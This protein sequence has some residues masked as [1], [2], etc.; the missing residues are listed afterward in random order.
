MTRSVAI[1][2]TIS[3]ACYCVGGYLSKLYANSPSVSLFLMA[4]VAFSACS[5]AWLPAMK[6]VNLLAVLGLIWSV[7]YVVADC[8]IGFGVFGERLTP[9]QGCGMIFG[10]VSIVLLNL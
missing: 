9:L 2:F 7:A 3:I 4:V 8:A 10:V 5:A 6:E 1:W